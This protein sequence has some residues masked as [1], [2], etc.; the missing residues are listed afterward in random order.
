MRMPSCTRAM[1]KGVCTN[2]P[3]RARGT[4]LNILGVADRELGDAHVPSNVTVIPATRTGG[5]IIAQTIGRCSKACVWSVAGCGFMRRCDESYL[6]MNPLSGFGSVAS[7]SHICAC[8]LPS[9]CRSSKPAR[10][11]VENRAGS[12]GWVTAKAVAEE[13]IPQRTR[14]PWHSMTNSS[15]QCLRGSRRT[16]RIFRR[17]TL[18]RTKTG[19]AP[20]A[21]HVSP[22]PGG[23]AHGVLGDGHFR[24]LRLLHFQAEI[25]VL[26][27]LGPAAGCTCTAPSE[28]HLSPSYHLIFGILA[29]RAT[30]SVAAN[31]T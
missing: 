23:S 27:V 8:C 14:C 11:G 15:G 29:P 18:L 5:N 1:R 10:R 12:G 4:H 19:Q 31:H 2:A 28:P 30:T 21:M 26:F 24:V 9:V 13:T 16:P 7:R 20:T 22:T 6:E 3:F 17:R 25:H